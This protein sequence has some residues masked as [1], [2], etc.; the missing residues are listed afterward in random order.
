M[1]TFFYK[2]ERLNCFFFFFM[3]VESAKGGRQ[4]GKE[5][6]RKT[7]IFNKG[8]QEF[9]DYVPLSDCVYDEALTH[10]CGYQFVQTVLRVDLNV[11]ACA[12]CVCLHART[13]LPFFYFPFVFLAVNCDTNY[14]VHQRNT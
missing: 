14:Y 11:C 12:V 5:K 4:F 3:C 1:C 7:Q 8:K 2:T 9:T 10:T 13:C 6:Q